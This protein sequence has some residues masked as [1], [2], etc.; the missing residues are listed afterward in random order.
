MKRPLLLTILALCLSLTFAQAQTVIISEF[1]AANQNGL[2]DEDGETSDWIE[3]YNS[4]TTSVNL[5]G[6][7][8]TDAAGNL[9]KW[10]FP[11]TT[12]DPNGFLVV[13][14]SSKDRAVSG[15]PLHANFKL[16]ADGGYLAL[17]RADAIVSSEYNPYP[18][19]YDDKPYGLQQVVS[20]T[21][22]IASGAAL[23]W[24]V[25]TTATP[26]DA[27]W[28]ARLFSDTSWTSGSNGVGFESTVTGF[29]FRTYFANVGV[30]SIATA[31]SVISTPSLQTQTYAETRGMVNYLDSGGDGHYAPQSNPSW[32]TGGANNYVVEATGI[33]TIPAAGAWTFGVN[34]DDGF[35]LQ[36][37]APGAPTWITVCSY[38]NGRATADTLGTHT[39]SAAG[40]YE[41]R[42]MIYEGSGGSA[43]E[44]FAK[45]GSF[46]SWDSGFALIGDTV[47]GGL[48][49][50][51][52][53]IGGSGSGYSGQIGVGSNTKAAMSDASPQ[54]AA[55]Y[56]RIP[57]TNPGGLASLTMPIRYDDGFVAYLNGTE[58]A[59]RNAPAGV[60]NN[61]T[62][63]SS[64][65]LP[66]QALST[67]NIDLTP[68]IG[69]L[70]AGAGN[71]LAIHGLNDSATGGDFLQKAELVRYNVTFGSVN[72][73]TTGT[74]GAFNTETIYNRVA[75]VTAS[76]GRGFYAAAQS[77]TLATGTPGATIRYTFDGSDPTE[78]AGTSATYSAPI[79]ISETRTL[80]YQAFK[81]TFDP[82][83]IV[84]QTYIFP[85]DVITQS[86]TGTPPVISNPSGAASST[87]TW[88]GTFNI[89]DGKYQVNG[90]ELDFGM[91]PD[92]VNAYSGTIV[93]DLKAIPS[94]S[95]VTPLP[96]LFDAT[97]GIYVNPGQDSI[98]AERPASIE[99]IYP[100]GTQGIQA[101]CGL[102]IRGGFSRSKDN[103]KHAFRLF[104]RDS[105][106]PSKLNF[107]VCGTT[108]GTT[109]EFDK[110]DL[111]CAQNYSWAFQ[112]DGGNGIF[113]RDKISRDMQLAMGSPSSHSVAYHLYVNG[114]YWG[115]Y[116][117]DERPDANFG[118]SYLGGADSDYDALKVD[119]D[120]S[121]N[122]EATDG[123]LDA[124]LS[125]WQLAD[126][127]TAA[128]GETSNNITY[129][130]L[131]GLNPDGTVN[132]AYPPLFDAVNTI[133]AML[134]VYYGGNLDAQISAFLGNN[135][136]NNTFF[137]RDRTGAH[138]GFRSV[139]HDSE[140]T[141]LN[142]NENRLGP[143]PAGSSTA[144]NG[145]GFGKSTP[146]YVFQQCMFSEEFRMLVADR[147][148]KHTSYSGVLTPAAATAIFD[149]RTSEIDRAVVAESAR[150]GDSKSNTP[151]TR[152]SNWVPAV[153]NVRNNFFPGRTAV[154]ISQMRTLG[155]YP[156][157]APPL[158]SQRGGTVVTGST[159]TL[160]H[161]GGQNA[162][163]YYTTD[164]SDPRMFG[165][166]INPTAT[167]YFGPIT[168]NASKFIR[169]RL[170]DGTT[171]S[172]IDEAAF[173][174]T[175]DFSALAITEIHY[176]PLPTTTGATDGEAYEFLELKNTGANM[177]DLGGLRFSGFTYVFPTGTTL[178]PGAFRVLAKDSAKFTARYGFAPGGLYTDNLKNGGELITLLTPT[179]TTVLTIDYNDAPPW[180]AAA[181]GAGFSIVPK[182]TNYNSDTG[183]NWRA[184]TNL[185]G[186]PGADDPASSIPVIVINEALTNSTGAPSDSIELRNPTA[187]SV[188]V[189][190]WWLS[191][192]RNA[193]QKYRIPAGTTIPAG[194]HVSF[195]E[196]QFNPTPGTGTSF[197][198]SS[199]SDEVYLFSGNAGGSLT[200]YS[201]GFDFAGGGLGV[202]F[203]RYVN[204]VSE[205]SFPR[206]ISRTFGSANSGPLVGPLVINEVMYH[207][208]AGYDE[209]IEIKNTS[210]STVLLYDPAN[211]ANTWEIGGIGY[212]FETNQSIPAGALA[213]V[214]GI[215]PATFR[216]KYN[217]P[218]GV[219]I[220]GPYAGVLQDSGERLSLEMPDTPVVEGA[221]TLVPYDVIDAVRYNDK[222]PWPVTADGSGPS[223]QR[224]SATAYADD[225]ANW[226]ASGASPGLANSVNQSPTVSLTAP[227]YGSTFTL[228]ATVTFTASA[229]DA[230]GSI[231]KVEFLVDGSKVG[232]A[233]TAPY[234]FNWTATGGAHT[235]TAVAIDNAL[236]FT[237]SASI[238]IY[239]TSPVTKGLR[240]DYFNNLTLTAP[241]AFTRID[242]QVNFDNGTW[243][244]FGGVG[245]ENFSVR[246]AGQI[247]VPTS[248][249]W[250]FFTQSDDGVRLYVNG[251]TLVDNWTHHGSTENSGTIS[252][253]AGVLYTIT[254]EFFQGG[255]GRVA[256]LRYQGP[257]NAK[258]IIPQSVLYPASA[259]IIVT[260]PLAISREVGT[261][262][263]FSVVASGSGNTYQ[264]LKGGFS[265]AGATS[266][267]LTIPY[268]LQSDAGSY[269]CLVSNADGFAAT[270]TVALT[271]TFTDSDNDGM[272]NSWETL[273]FGST[274]AAVASLDA[275]GDGTTNL[276]EFLAGTDPKNA[277]SKLT[278]T[279][280][281]NASN[282]A[283][284]HFTAQPYKAYT[285]QYKNSLTDVS[286][287]RLTDI[288]LAPGV[289]AIDVTDTTGTA[290]TKR[291]YR[292]ITPQ[293]P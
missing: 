199:V 202:S 175:Q 150:W 169:T 69:S 245:T 20:T 87:T 190:D 106:G 287:I 256:Q 44:A 207:P 270:N 59:R 97:T 83:D 166:A 47:A 255:G 12:L 289:R 200:G 249:S 187:S 273:Y 222:L 258:Q 13:F 281:R 116:D 113:V 253:T 292:V 146:Q 121:Y 194:G 185:H 110:F 293:A 226:F 144:L 291:F 251:Q 163:I 276:Q 127:M 38:D 180:P 66:S 236:G 192:D 54:K 67:E 93:N 31:N 243:V 275:D 124:W 252:L 158:W 167:A 141:L 35:Q 17:V 89:N 183:S 49:V 198:L 272:Q 208:Y 55:C 15:A 21:P 107:P 159:F 232:E 170:K 100:D 193:P 179:D 209:Y 88:P 23:K 130:R 215:D 233:T 263:V 138:G 99:V 94:I 25:P 188:N 61:L 260:Q 65:R 52:I 290:G 154:L 212:V 269:S 33:V 265:L 82:S 241:L 160:S 60:P 76:V 228:P 161:T 235:C 92:V 218:V 214:V 157:I 216:T 156:S 8:L 9:S 40:D 264:W 24:L 112:G 123:N 64:D 266:S 102:R 197:A 280:T 133:D 51:S 201:H 143:W 3:I 244:N 204:S 37:R 140:H 229:A 14:A 286:W 117:T 250:T 27:T 184:S 178:A 105:Y 181:D 174:V 71:V 221:V 220:F 224:T 278:S 271:V 114:Q 32:V 56:V 22:L 279:V 151:F 16:S 2:L 58:V 120:L 26:N 240:A 95:I 73:Y 48:A 139:L 42:V 148:Y 189:G 7:R 126:G 152:D 4:G 108:A 237:T 101:N 239:V 118:E 63:A 90:Q 259:P 125:L 62:T 231:T 285:V 91:D 195:D 196:S 72:Y 274:T 103:P 153:N 165:G 77:V 162:T 45:Q 36:V 98:T 122:I 111:R 119:P 43:G 34:S 75:P 84:T 50:K 6:W 247:V 134:V 186:S 70:V 182:G 205:E 74:P 10:I 11:A 248:G 191:D 206:Q 164:G 80:R 79:S 81:A 155:W 104:F 284:I 145:G 268:V 213:L 246:W 128:A 78:A 136:P 172:A 288:A 39:F 1:M 177:L 46:G 227:A 283:V 86:P 129:Q 210:G 135:S 19:Q 149:A 96:N 242:P 131:L 261:S 173:Y 171:W 18:A 85:T 211:P 238:P 203:G 277:A 223:L 230:D 57:F 109:Q 137:F 5:A 53:P 29:A 267:I 217:V 254:M 41:I 147:T 234:T 262:A 132:A 257:S 68:F 219:Q 282:Q 176:N 168:I 28:T 30:G 142:V 225:P 115:L